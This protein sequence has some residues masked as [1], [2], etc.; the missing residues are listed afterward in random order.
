MSSFGGRAAYV[1]SYRIE[2]RK[3][4]V[5]YT[6]GSIKDLHDRPTDFNGKFGHLIVYERE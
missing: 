2:G 1:G 5:V 4:T 3:L 6:S